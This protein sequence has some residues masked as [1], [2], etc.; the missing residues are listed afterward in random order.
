MWWCS[1]GLLFLFLS[2]RP[3]PSRQG[4]PDGG[5]IFPASLIG[6]GLDERLAGANMPGG[7]RKMLGRR[8]PDIFR[9]CPAAS[10]VFCVSLV[11]FGVSQEPGPAGRASGGNP[12][13]NA[14]PVTLRVFAGFRMDVIHSG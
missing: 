4:S 5:G 6:C 8:F 2:C 7:A 12:L 14:Q 13:R 1:D 10:A 3:R 9:A 11:W